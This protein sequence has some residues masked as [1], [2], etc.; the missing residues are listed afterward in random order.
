ME[1]G[2]EYVCVYKW[3]DSK[4][5]EGQETL[6]SL[7]NQKVKGEMMLSPNSREIF[8]FSWLLQKP[9]ERKSEEF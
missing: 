3:K 1:E 5:L 9:T 6:A 7:T 2:L 8:R 4:N